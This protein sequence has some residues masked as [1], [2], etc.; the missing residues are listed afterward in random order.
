MDHEFFAAKVEVYKQSPTNHR[1]IIVLDVC[2]WNKVPF[3]MYRNKNH[4]N[5]KLFGSL[6]LQTVFISIA[7]SFI[8]F[9]KTKKE[10]N[11]SF[12]LEQR[13][14]AFDLKVPKKQ[15]TK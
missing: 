12:A 14:R 2:S 3:L 9:L 10:K 7:E 4:R 15:M 11:K 13:K 8:K 5:V 6:H 1:L